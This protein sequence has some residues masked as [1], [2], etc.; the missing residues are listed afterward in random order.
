[1]SGIIF[2]G[3]SFTHGHGLWFYCKDLY[4]QYKLDS[5]FNSI[6]KDRSVHHLKYKDILRFPR[7]VSQELEM[8]EITREDYSGNDEDSIKFINHIFDVYSLNPQWSKNHYKY[9]DN[10]I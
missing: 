2:A 9:D 7:L 6:L 1:M 3:C 5:T 8:F 10:M 4:S